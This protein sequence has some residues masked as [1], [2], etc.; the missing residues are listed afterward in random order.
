MNKKNKAIKVRKITFLLCNAVSIDIIVLVVEFVVE[1]MRGNLRVN[2]IDSRSLNGRCSRKKK[3]KLQDWKIRFEDN[4]QF[5]D[6]ESSIS[7]LEVQIGHVE[8]LDIF[9]RKMKS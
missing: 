2:R 6:L 4:Q 9:V 8:D 5:P 3:V 7:G 1:S